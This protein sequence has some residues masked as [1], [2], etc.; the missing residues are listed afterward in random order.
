MAHRVALYQLTLQ[1]PPP[2]A[3]LAA[4]GQ[5]KPGRVFLTHPCCGCTC[6]LVLPAGKGDAPGTV[7]QSLRDILGDA[8]W[9]ETVVVWMPG[10]GK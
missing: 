3:S 7:C 5:L 4:L 6:P 9:A 8:S 10:N 1:V 2:A